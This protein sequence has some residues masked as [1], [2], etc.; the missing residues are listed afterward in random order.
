MPRRPGTA[1]PL[2]RLVKTAD[3]ERV[4]G[5]RRRAATAHFAVHHLAA[6]PTLAGQ[7][8]AASCAGEVIN[9]FGS[10]R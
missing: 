4:L 2:A 1:G 3:F 6:R 9:N 8:G 10:C 5:V 7:A